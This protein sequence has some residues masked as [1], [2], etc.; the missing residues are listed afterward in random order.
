MLS[1]HTE[2]NF[3]GFAQGDPKLNKINLSIHMHY[4]KLYIKCGVCEGGESKRNPISAYQI[5][6][7]KK[8]EEHFKVTNVV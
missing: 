4:K 7:E 3:N 5:P 6:D 8:N 2:K 1:L